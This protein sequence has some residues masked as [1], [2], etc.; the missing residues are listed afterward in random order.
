M[1][2]LAIRGRLPRGNINLASTALGGPGADPAGSALDNA[3]LPILG[4]SASLKTKPATY[5]STYR[6]PLI[7]VLGLAMYLTLIGPFMPR[8][9]NA[10][11]V[12]L[13]ALNAAP[14][15]SASA[16]DTV[17]Q[18][19]PPSYASSTPR[20][21]AQ[22]T[23]AIAQ[24][25]LSATATAAA[26]IRNTFAHVRG[27]AAAHAP[28]PQQETSSTPLSS[29]S[30][31]S[32]ANQPIALHQGQGFDLV[33]VN[34]PN[35]Q[36]QQHG[37]ESGDSAEGSA[38]P[39]RDALERST[40][41][42]SCTPRCTQ[43][44]TCVDGQCRC[45][46]PYF[47]PG[48]S[49]VKDIP[50][51]LRPGPML[52][53]SFGFDGEM[54]VSKS[55]LDKRN[56]KLTVLLPGKQDDPDGGFRTLAEGKVFDALREIS[57]P[58]DLL[59]SQ[60]HA[61]CAIVGSSGIVLSY[62]HGEEIDAH[63]MVMRFNSAP[64]KGFEKHVG[65]KTTHR[66]TNTQNWGFHESSSELLLIHFRA[67]SALKGL[68]WNADQIKTNGKHRI[69][70]PL[71]AFDPE[72][73]EYIAHSLSFMATSGLYGILIAIQTCAS[74]SLYGFQVS[75]NHGVPYHYYDLCDVP[76][77]VGRDG[78]EWYVVKALVEHGY[79]KFAEP[80]IVECHAGEGDCEVCK[81]TQGFTP[82]PFST[83]HCDPHRVSQGHLVV[84][85]RREREA[86]RSGGHGGHGR[87]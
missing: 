49:L 74:V 60:V 3:S 1:A 4:P 72:F 73:V 67:V 76:A 68:F 71:V 10:A 25:P 79:A 56:R 55:G 24:A 70:N 30:S 23:T 32:T 33:D 84:P 31:S 69:P 81:Q 77:N 57:P 8:G 6:A 16:A 15:A 9:K 78:A 28:P 17:A 85:W 48:C 53:L 2:D 58:N 47:G 63:D 11:P 64:A 7:V 12:P 43:H 83:D 42:S 45:A 65:S 38:D 80:C 39:E 66:I 37:D 13:R 22:T 5:L 29:S 82:V 86:R 87:G 40:D 50:L 44:G 19:T 41:A 51:E 61:K 46:V 27:G 59:R 62:E 21:Q 52:N 36:Q 54:S 75:T 26:V 14:S 34:T 18:L 35:D 20:T